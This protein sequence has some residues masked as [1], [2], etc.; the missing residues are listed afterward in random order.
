M[1]DDCLR[2]VAE[3]LS[4][5]TRRSQMIARYGGEEFAVILPGETLEA[6]RQVA[7]RLRAA[8][9]DLALPHEGVGKTVTV[10][11]GAASATPTG[12]QGARQLIEAADRNL[13]EAKRAGRNRVCTGSPLDA[14]L[15]ASGGR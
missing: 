6:A 8:V 5:T 12:P 13:Y 11:L 15:P 3:Q 10:S 7:E 9:E 4:A 14:P 2:R 1:G